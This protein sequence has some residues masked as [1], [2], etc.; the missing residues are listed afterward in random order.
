MTCDLITQGRL[1]VAREPLRNAM[2]VNRKVNGLLPNE[3]VA[4]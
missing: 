4:K 2:T 1:L 3:Q